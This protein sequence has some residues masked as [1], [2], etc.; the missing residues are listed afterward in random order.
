MTTSSQFEFAVGSQL[1]PQEPYIKKFIRELQQGFANSAS[2]DGN[3][4]SES[5]N[6]MALYTHQ[7]LNF[8]SGHRAVS[9][10][11][12]DLHCFDLTDKTL[13]IEEKVVSSTHATRL[14]WLPPLAV[15]QFEHYLSHLRSLS[16]LLRGSYPALANQIWAVTEPNFRHPI[17][18]FFFLEERDGDLKWI[19]I[20]PA[21]LQSMLGDKWELP[22][23]TN[24]HLLSTWLHTNKCPSEFIDAQLGHVEAGCY[25]FS[26]RSVLSP[27]GIGKTIVPLLQNYLVEQGWKAIKGIG[28]P[29][30]YPIIPPSPKSK[31][32]QS[33]LLFGP[34]A[35]TASR[36]AVWRKDATMII[37][38][39][40]SALPVDSSRDIP[41]S[42]IDSMQDKLLSEYSDDGRVLIRLSLF[43]RH[44]ISLRRK[45][46]QV[47][48]PGRLALISSEPACFSIESSKEAAQFKGIS[49]RFLA[50]LS[51]QSGHPPMPEVR[52]AEILISSCIFGAQ[53]SPQFLEVVAKGF[54]DRICRHGDRVFVDVSRGPAAPIRRWFPDNVSW[55]LVVGYSKLVSAGSAM[56]S[57]EKINDYLIKILDIIKAP[58]PK[59]PPS[60]REPRILLDHL[61]SL[62][63]S[64]W[65][66]R[67]PGSV[68]A[69]AE[70]EYACASIPLSNWLR[71][72]SDKRG[73]LQPHLRAPDF[74]AYIDDI[75]PI[76]RPEQAAIDYKQAKQCWSDLTRCLGKSSGSKSGDALARSNARKKSIETKIPSYLKKGKSNIPPILQLVA[77]WILHLSRSGTSTTP[78]VRASTVA[79]YA[80]SIGEKL[81][82][83]AYDVDFLSQSDVAVEEIYRNVLEVVS[84]ENRGYVAGRLKEFHAFLV[85]S[86]AM[87]KLDWSEIVDDD[88]LEADVVDAGIVSLPE[89][90]KALETL[91]PDQTF[92]SRDQLLRA[93]ILF[94]AYRFG[95]RAG[96]IFRLTIS[97]IIF[98]DGE[99]IVYIRNSIYG[100][101][102]SSNGVRQLPLLGALS[103]AEHDLVKQ[104]LSHIETFADGDH[105]AALFSDVE[106]KRC[107]AN[108]STCVSAVVEVLRKVTGEPE[109][110]LRHLRHTCATRLYLAMFFD[111]T[112]LGFVGQ[113]YNALWG[114]MTPQAVRSILIGDARVSRR[115]LYA[116]AM[117][118]GHGSPDITHRH[119]I[120]LAD[121]LLKEWIEREPPGIDDKTLA[122]ACQ[123]SYAN[124]RQ[125]RSRYATDASL[126]FLLEHFTRKSGIPA[127][128]LNLFSEQDAPELNMT[129]PAQSSLT[130]SDID[131]LLAIATMRDSID[132]LAE[133]F[134]ISD[135]QVVSVLLSASAIQEETGYAAFSIPARAP[136]DF[137]I[138]NKGARQDTLDKES[139]RVRA[140]LE[141]MDQANLS[142]DEL[143]DVARIWANSFHPSSSCLLINKR[144]D[145]ERLLACMKTIGIPSDNFEVHIPNDQIENN[146][147]QWELTQ[148]WLGTRGLSVYRRDRLPLSASKLNAENRVGLILRASASHELGYQQT[149]NRALF[150]TSIWLSVFKNGFKVNASFAREEDN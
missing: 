92:P 39:I 65:R 97:D 120:H 98:L 6:S 78:D 13:L 143:G 144:N 99:M 53:T 130:P 25:P 4:L 21:T 16:R 134:L 44:L 108:R 94:F 70:G 119:Y 95:L 131:R 47:K 142:V 15:S 141:R 32:L 150:V 139:R 83:L 18:L 61:A 20:Q 100:E 23:N 57:A 49:E 12:F 9:D 60:K 2:A 118:M 29:S 27:Q 76:H 52:L 90:Y 105:L 82:A 84:C 26:G 75:Q 8:A 59:K 102:K 147:A 17:P 77:A 127:P 19:R 62:A 123:T 85:Y 67:L 115:G 138:F 87:P 93:V 66:F 109:T 74:V 14:A 106:S 55:P 56:P 28:A 51:S 111:K 30:R 135:G 73:T 31:D 126:V 132:G 133:R 58:Y 7:M 35:R 46:Y 107:V 5:H 72:V 116:M 50:Y 124:I 48:I 80:R 69:Y 86:Y 33:T 45:G 110:R 117:Y 148:S 10:P 88:S 145:L 113:L 11:Y 149:L 79:A 54:R 34:H 129:I 64:Y 96:E 114:E 63:Q 101:T 3:S 137:W 68:R 38:L 24:R 89:Y 37:S 71:F 128:T 41:D 104:W 22:L 43:R 125:L 112:P 81:N 103:K 122:Y 146:P 40:E 91:L 36:E 1:T 140:F 121:V 136:D 42:L